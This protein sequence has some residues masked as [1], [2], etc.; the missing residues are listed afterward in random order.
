M[1]AI[2][3]ADSSATAQCGPRAFW[4]ASAYSRRAK[5]RSGRAGHR[6]TSL[7]VVLCTKQRLCEPGSPFGTILFEIR[8]CRATRRRDVGGLQF[9]APRR[10]PRFFLRL[11]RACH[12]KVSTGRTRGGC[13]GLAISVASLRSAFDLPQRSQRLADSIT[14]P[15]VGHTRGKLVLWR[16][17]RCATSTSGRRIDPDLPLELSSMSDRSRQRIVF[18]RGPIETGAAHTRSRRL[19]L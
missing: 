12:A 5:R 4:T 13:R 6:R 7:L 16:R 14:L 15:I 8:V 2:S 10:P 11:A 9:S 17:R 19:R 18:Q 3:I 1:R